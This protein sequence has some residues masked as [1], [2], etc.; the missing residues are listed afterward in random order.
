MADQEVTIQLPEVRESE[1][2]A[3]RKIAVVGAGP[4]GLSCAY[5]LARL[6]Y[7]PKVFEGSARPGGMLVQAIPA[8]R[9]P[10][11]I[12]AREVRMIENMGVELLTNVWLGEDFTLEVLRAEGYDAVFLGVG[13]PQGIKLA[14]PG[15]DAQGVADALAF[16][17]T[18]NQRGSVL[19]GKEVVVIGGG[20]SAIDAARTAVR[21][22]AEKVSVV[23]RR[24]REAMPAYE[25]EIEEAEHE[26]VVLR[27]LTAPVQI[28][29]EGRH[30]A[31]VKCVPVRLGAF[32]RSGRRRPEERGDAF[33][34]PADQVLVA[35]GQTLDTKPILG[36]LSLKTRND[37]FLHADRVSGQTSEKWIFAGGDAVS[38]PSSVVEAVAAGERAAAGI[39]M[40]LTGANHAF[41][42]EDKP[43]DTAFDPE[44]DPSD[45]PRE[46]LNLIGVQRRRNNFDEVEMPWTE[47][48]AVRQ[49]GRCLRCDYGKQCAANGGSA[50]AA[51][52]ESV[53]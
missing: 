12:V 19:V 36:E 8:Y 25:E 53:K 48:V 6:G 4:A 11:E 52:Q 22:G 15:E 24:S 37:V 40:Y 44:A 29:A 34:I 49:A 7:R 13:A 23:Y 39:D 26:G 17:R 43:V 1:R 47:A 10:R 28:I 18:Y 50:Q 27:L 30:V 31:G 2:N 3:R 14:M 9:L 51:S 20:N 5:F 32:D 41:W 38:G 16:L 35:I 21:L 45:A 46:G 42:R 33:V